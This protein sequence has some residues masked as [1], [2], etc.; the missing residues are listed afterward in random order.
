MLALAHGKDGI[1]VNT[2]CP[3]WTEAVPLGRAGTP[4]EGAAAVLALAW[5]RAG[6]TTGATLVVDGGF[7]S[8]H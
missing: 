3:G 4:E 6:Y 1:R 7:A 8:G 2:V 5:D